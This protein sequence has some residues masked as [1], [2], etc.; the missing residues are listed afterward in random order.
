MDSVVGFSLET[1]LEMA[2]MV[3]ALDET[4]LLGVK[5]AAER[6]VY[7]AFA[8]GLPKDFLVIHSLQLVSGSAWGPHLDMESDFVI[9]APSFGLL[10]IEVKG[11]G[12]EHEGATGK[13]F[14]VNR[15]G[16]HLVKDPFKQAMRNKQEILRALRAMSPSGSQH[17]PRMLAGHAVLFPDLDRVSVLDGA[18]R[19]IAI[20]GGRSALASPADWVRSVFD[21]WAKGD[22]EWNPLGDREIKAIEE[23]FCA[24]V[25]LTVPLA[26]HIEREGQRQIELTNRQARIL[27]MLSMRSRAAIAGGAGTGKTLLALRH[28]KDL[29]A[30]GVETLL[31]C[32]NQMLG[33]FL[34]REAFR[35]PRLNTMTFHE[36][37]NWRIQTVR[38]EFGLDLLA[39]AKRMYPGQSLADVVWPYAMARS[40]EVHPFRYAAII[41]DEGQDF[42]DEWWLGLELLLQEREESHFYVFYDPNQAVYRHSSAFPIR[43]PP[44]CLTENCRNTQ[45]IHEKAYRYYSGYTIDP[46]DIPGEK[47]EVLVAPDVRSQARVVR[48][49]VSALIVHEKI[50]PEDIAVLIAPEGKGD[51]YAA[52]GQ[53]DPPLGTRWS[54]ETLWEPGAVLVDTARR[55]K[56]LEAAAVILWGIDLLDPAFD[57]ELLYVSLSRAR[58]R[59]WLVGSDRTR[60]TAMC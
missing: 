57:K 34:K 45:A 2:R 47:P 19:P 26:L 59:I 10:V 39:E 15:D 21:F 44:L 27:R 35:V 52:L 7:R 33:D 20:I 46:P 11:G 36:L 38:A 58:S 32:Y 53:G 6:S 56:G 30:R 60:I 55:F 1:S 25:R 24:S 37:C 18:D 49:T 12:I 31:V 22:S 54:F 29:A 5:S 9:L 14:S 41:V 13:W 42:G 40:T 23:F 8:D 4:D 3:P 51:Y 43:D 50:R 28:A 17:L 48:Q 16:R